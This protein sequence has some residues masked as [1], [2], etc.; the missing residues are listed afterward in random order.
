MPRSNWKRA[1]LLAGPLAFAALLLLDTPLRHWGEYGARPAL[2]AG[3]T[4][5][6]AIWW[7]SEA[8]PIHWTA[9][10][11]LFVLPFAG[12]HAGGVGAGTLG[13]LLPYVNPYIFLFL[14]GMGIAA[15]MQQW[16]LDR[17]IALGILRAVG[18]DPRRLLLG[19]L[20]ATAA[21]SLWISNTATAAMMFPIG[22]AL[23]GEFERQVGSRLHHYGAAIMLAVAY[24]SNIGGI[25]T[26]IGTV[27]SAQLSG[28]LAQRG[29]EVDFF[30]FMA[31]GM[32]FVA[33]MLPIA[34][35]V[36]WR[37]GRPDAP[38]AG[39]ARATL[40]QQTALLGPMKRG[41]RVVLVVFVATAV[42]WIAAK[43]ICDWLKAQGLSD[44]QTSQVEAGAAI[45]A[46]TVL[47]LWRA[48]RQ[49]V[50]ALRSLRTIQWSVL[51][52]LGGGFSLAA[53]IETSGLSQWMGAQLGL[54]RAQP[55]LVQAV[56]ASLV[57]VTLSAFASNAAT[58][59][60]MLPV[61]AG[62]VAP[63]HLN[64]VLF[65]ATFSASCDFAL[66]AGT[67][68]NAIVFGSGYV[69]IPTM[70]R[71]GVRLDLLAA[72]LAA[73]WCWFAVPWVI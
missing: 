15:A 22:L 11:P 17:R 61:L 4:L 53:A 36:L 41:E 21:I 29:V 40:E 33:F 59:A 45:A 42:L 28:F 9:C 14:G 18:T 66:P 55:G 19:V 65:A 2:A 58:V 31:I 1:A 25:G 51:V 57:T 8:L 5:W 35:L 47:A 12:I 7:I 67:P 16:K 72:L 13:A 10:L 43:Q 27:P 63:E 32:P 60:V 34:W 24:A 26:K 6:M 70:V 38:D 73:V 37:V 39:V 71:T 68:P 46:S 48:D 50:L 52:V 56:V 23:I 69:S 30:Q 62:S 3:L 64:A 44:L 54:L 20:V 49:P